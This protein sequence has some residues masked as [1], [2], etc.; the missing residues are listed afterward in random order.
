MDRPDWIDGELWKLALEA[1]AKIVGDHFIHVDRVSNFHAPNPA[2]R[3]LIDALDELFSQIETPIPKR[4]EKRVT[5]QTKFLDAVANCDYRGEVT[6]QV[7]CKL[8]GGREKLVDV[9]QCTK[10]NAEC[11]IDPHKSG[12]AERVCKRCEVFN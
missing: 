10:F 9:Y 8:C 6:R 5:K 12:Q 3:K 7:K 2:K 4:I 1:D 11:T